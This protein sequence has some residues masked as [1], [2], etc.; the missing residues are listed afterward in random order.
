MQMR[1][2]MI[3]MDFELLD[4]SNGKVC[5]ICLNRLHEILRR[6]ARLDIK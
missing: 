3:R 4:A 1:R 2:K 5:Y 6:D